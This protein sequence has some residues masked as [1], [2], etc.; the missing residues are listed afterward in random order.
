M[1]GVKLQDKVPGKW[2]RERLGLDD[3]ISAVQKNRLWRYTNVLWKEDNDWV[4]RMYRV[5]K[6]KSKFI[7]SRRT[8]WSL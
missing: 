5:F 8:W 1:C 7:K 3:I 4:G 2:F 6:F